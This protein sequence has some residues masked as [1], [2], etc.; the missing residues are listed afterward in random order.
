MS[1]KKRK[2]RKKHRPQAGTA[3]GSIEAPADS[4]STQIWTVNYSA[5]ELQEDLNLPLEGLKE[6]THSRVTWLAVEGLK[7]V[8]TLTSLC[9]EFDIHRLALDEIAYAGRPRFENFDS[10]LLLTFPVLDAETGTAEMVSLLL[11]ESELMTFQKKS[12]QNFREPILERLRNKR[13]VIRKRGVDY[14]AYAV[15]DNT[16]DRFFPLV[17]GWTRELE[18]LGEQVESS[19]FDANGVRHIRREAANTRRTLRQL[20][21]AVSALTRSSSH[22]IADETRV[23]YRDCMEHVMDLVEELDRVRD[24]TTEILDSHQSHL[25]KKSSDAMQTLTVVSSIFI[26]LS[27]IAGLYGM[28]FDAS[29]SYWN[30]PELRLAYGYPLVLSVMLVIFV[31]LVAYFRKRKLL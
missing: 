30:M 15:L 13:G 2:M 23:F 19:D 28:N 4:E 8:E 11:G 26:P 14:L 20:R 10:Y 6:L 18:S 9:T 1:N 17:D 25:N 21:D 16:I 31:V 24:F 7:S 3:P 5:D 12:Y 27:F 22:L 29:V